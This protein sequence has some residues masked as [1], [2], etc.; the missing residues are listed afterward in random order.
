LQREARIALPGIG[1]FTVQERAARTGRNP[2][3]G[4]E[5]QIPARKTV[6]FKTAKEI[7][8]AVV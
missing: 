3:T 6:K 5:I 2:A 4:Q 7:A 8:D 1:I